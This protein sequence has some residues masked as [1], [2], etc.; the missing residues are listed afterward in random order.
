[1]PMN[2]IHFQPGLSL[3]EFQRQYG[4]E[5]QCR[6]ALEHA[7]GHKGFAVRIVSM[8]PATVFRDETIPCISVSR[9][10]NKPR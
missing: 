1:M 3:L 9:V 4:T 6:Q 2:R 5:D 8:M 10:A 7:P